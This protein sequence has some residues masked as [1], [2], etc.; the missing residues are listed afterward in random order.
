MEYNIQSWKIKTGNAQRGGIDSQPAP[1]SAVRAGSGSANTGAQSIKTGTTVSVQSNFQE[2][3][4]QQIDERLGQQLQQQPRRQAASGQPRQPVS[5]I[6]S[7]VTPPRETVHILRKGENVWSLAKKKYQV[8]PAEMLRLNKIDDPRNLQVG[9][10]L[11]I[12]AGNKESGNN[13]EETVV[14]SW[15]GKSHQGKIMANGAPFDMYG[16]TI[17]H[18]DIAIG[19][20]VELENPQTGEKAK[21][22]VTDRG[23]FVRNR[24]IDLSYGLAKRLSIARQGVGNLKMRVL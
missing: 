7:S 5:P 13:T 22:V 24:D 10:R 18:R 12:P 21:A 16:A 14:A 11:R 23:P 19:T 8:D 6:S 9:Q 3:L 15:Y 20:K 1:Q 2:F 4:D 17:A